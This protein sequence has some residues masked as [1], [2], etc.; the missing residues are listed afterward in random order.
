MLGNLTKPDP[1]DYIDPYLERELWLGSKKEETL[2]S[3][4]L[5]RWCLT[6]EE[7]NS[8]TLASTSVVGRE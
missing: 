1:G 2:T 4:T 7:I 8:G 3:F 5:G 6:S